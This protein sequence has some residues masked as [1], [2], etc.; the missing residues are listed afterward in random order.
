[1]Y[2]KLGFEEQFVM[3]NYSLPASVDTSADD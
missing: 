1:M 3:K 2:L